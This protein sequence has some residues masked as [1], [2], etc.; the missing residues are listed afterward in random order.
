MTLKDALSLF[1]TPCYI[2]S[3]ICSDNV[4]ILQACRFRVI[5]VA[6]SLTSSNAVDRVRT[7]AKA[8]ST[9]ATMSN[10]I[11]SFRQSRNKLN[12]LNLFQHCRKDEISFDIVAETGN[13]LLPKPATMSK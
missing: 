12:M 4:S 1:D 3:V 9:P 10:E 5:K 2:L 6:F 11:L 7:R 13:I 8:P